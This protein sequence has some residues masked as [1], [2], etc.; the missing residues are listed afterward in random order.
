MLILPLIKA[1]F[2]PLYFSSLPGYF[3]SL[4]S[5]LDS[6]VTHTAFLGNIECYPTVSNG[7]W[8]RQGAGDTKGIYRAGTPQRWAW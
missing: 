7:S 4:Y 3:K 2:F 6:E 5:L 8:S 1:D